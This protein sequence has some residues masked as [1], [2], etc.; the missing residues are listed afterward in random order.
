MQHEFG[1]LLHAM[2]HA[3]LPP[4]GGDESDRTPQEDRPH[5]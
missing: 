2:A 1:A 3:P 5:E 4:P